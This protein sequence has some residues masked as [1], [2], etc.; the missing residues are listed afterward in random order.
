VKAREK[1]ER[2][3]EKRRKEEPRIAA[4]GQLHH[5]IHTSLRT[6]RY[7]ISFFHPPLSFGVRLHLGPHSHCSDGEV[8]ARNLF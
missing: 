4:S 5:I 1:E 3:K 2:K 7:V 8:S 6:H